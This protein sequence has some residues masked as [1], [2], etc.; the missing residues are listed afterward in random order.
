MAEKSNISANIAPYG[1]AI[2]NAL[3]KS[4]TPIDELIALRDRARE[5]IGIQ[6]DLA[7]AVKALDT[8]IA[9]RAAAKAAPPPADERFVI[10]LDGIALPDRTKAK[11]EQS[12]QKVVMAEIAKIDTGGDLV[13]TPLSKAKLMPAIMGPHFPGGIVMGFVASR[14]L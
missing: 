5:L 4:T 12:L 8:E 6:G 7:A 1:I 9:G 10:Q 2:G 11:I 3:S 14:P 13:A